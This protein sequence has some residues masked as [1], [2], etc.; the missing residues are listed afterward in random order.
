M[1]SKRNQRSTPTCPSC[2]EVETHRHVL[3]CQSNQ[4][5]IAFRTIERNFETWLQ[6]TTSDAIQLAIMKHLQ[7]YRNEEYIEEPDEWSRQ[8]QTASINQSALGPC[9]FVEG[10]VVKDWE[11]MQTEHLNSKNSKRNPGRWVK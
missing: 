1:L 10:F 5:T 6:A 11:M 7:G 3:R 4:A 8:V 2:A 9:A